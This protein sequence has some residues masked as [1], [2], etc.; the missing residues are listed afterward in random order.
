M[1]GKQQCANF[2]YLRSSDRGLR[3]TFSRRVQVHRGRVLSP[4][5]SDRPRSS[6]WYSRSEY[7]K[8]RQEITEFR[9]K[10]RSLL[11]SA[12]NS[13]SVSS[14]TQVLEDEHHCIRGLEHYLFPEFTVETERRRGNLFSMLSKASPRLISSKP[15]HDDELAQAC[16]ELT[17]QSALEAVER[18]LA[19]AEAIIGSSGQRKH[20]SRLPHQD[21]GA[22]PKTF[23]NGLSTSNHTAR[24]LRR[25]QYTLNSCAV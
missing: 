13:C 18:A 12:P 9:V 4:E 10:C 24:A 14:R 15:F 20:T 7:R 19:D 22:S 5:E 17:R 25:A 2:D 23:S 1:S 3:V 6:F 21:K 16:R 8:M 11:E